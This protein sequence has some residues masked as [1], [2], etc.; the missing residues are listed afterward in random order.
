M[1]EPGK[2]FMKDSLR[3]VKRCTK[4][5]SRRHP[6]LTSSSPAMMARAGKSDEMQN[7]LIGLM[8]GC[9]RQRAKIMDYYQVSSSSK[10][11]ASTSTP[12][13]LRGLSWPQSLIDSSYIWF[14]CKRQR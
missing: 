10:L 5:H 8:L 7:F 4:P 14:S 13:H 9:R 11:A 2:Q 12:C 6:H 1:L 3:L